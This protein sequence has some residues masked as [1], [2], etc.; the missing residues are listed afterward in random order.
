[1]ASKKIKTILIGTTN[2]AKYRLYND[3]L[4]GLK[5]YGIEIK[6]LP[7]DADAALI[8]KEASD[9]LTQNAV[10]KAMTY[11]RSKKMITIADDT[12]FFIPALNNEPGVAVRRWG[13]KLP[14]NISDAEWEKYFLTRLRE[15]PIREPKAIKSLVIACSNPAGNHQTSEFQ[16]TGTIKVPGCG[17]YTAGGPL[18][19]YFFIDQCNRFEAELT[20]KEKDIL[21]GELKL[22]L[23]DMLL[24]YGHLERGSRNSLEIGA[25]IIQKHGTLTTQKGG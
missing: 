16:I 21:F 10:Q 13:G 20:Q 17:S 1:M 19:S 15:S 2:E 6:K 4:S 18:S 23:I 24:R 7:E 3:I 14:S 5:E 11:A 8:V 9:S 12:G 25:E 22:K